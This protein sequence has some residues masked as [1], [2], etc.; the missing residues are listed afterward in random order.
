[1]TDLILSHLRHPGTHV[2]GFWALDMLL[3]KE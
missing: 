1:M 2:R 3:G